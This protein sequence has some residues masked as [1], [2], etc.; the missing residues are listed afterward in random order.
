MAHTL[1][2]ITIISEMEQYPRVSCCLVV[3]AILQLSLS[4]MDGWDNPSI[5]GSNMGIRIMKRV[6]QSV[7]RISYR[8]HKRY[9]ELVQILWRNIPSMVSNQS[10]KLVIQIF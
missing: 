9:P 8:N 2:M 5:T 7:H 10:T 3:L 6:G 4:Q 1:V